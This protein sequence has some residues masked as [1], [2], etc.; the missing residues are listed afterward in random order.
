MVIF[1]ARQT[2]LDSFVSQNL[3]CDYCGNTGSTNIHIVSSYF[4]IFWIPTFHIYKA[5]ITECGHCKHTMKQAEM[6]AQ[7]K[8]QVKEAK[9]LARIKAWEFAGLFIVLLALALLTILG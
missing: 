7:V 3:P 5:G 4:H 2:H 6:P 1:G 9:K 8:Q